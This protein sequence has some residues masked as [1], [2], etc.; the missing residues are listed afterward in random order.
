[1]HSYI[2]Q[3]L[4]CEGERKD[5]PGIFTRLFGFTC[6]ADIY[7]TFR[8][9]FGTKYISIR[10]RDIFFAGGGGTNTNV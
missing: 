9:Y 5:S 10:N 3:R 6:Y 1:M 2:F 8:I 7:Y 4:F